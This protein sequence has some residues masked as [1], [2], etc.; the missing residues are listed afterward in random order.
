MRMIDGDKLAKDLE[1]L[2]KHED[3]F[4]QSVILGVVHTVKAQPTVDAAEVVHGRWKEWYPPMHTILTGEEMLYLCSACDAKYP[5]A[6]GYRY[7]PRCGAMMDEL[8]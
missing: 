5:D 7:C 2:A 8:V 4:R 6:E 3:G 1:L